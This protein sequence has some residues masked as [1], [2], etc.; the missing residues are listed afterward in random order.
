MFSISVVVFRR[1]GGAW[2][3][4][5]S[6]R[7]QGSCRMPSCT[8]TTPWR[9]HKLVK[10]CHVAGAEPP[11]PCFLCSSCCAPV[12]CTVQCKQKLVTLSRF[13]CKFWL[14]CDCPLVSPGSR[15]NGAD[16][17]CTVFAHVATLLKPS[18]WLPNF[19]FLHSCLYI[20]KCSGA[21]VLLP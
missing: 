10:A 8:M 12:W 1:S 4:E 16:L 11:G 17:F 18:T 20:V 21:F 14:C 7:A 5:E 3:F 9:P 15:A 2:A 6:F 13:V 19:V